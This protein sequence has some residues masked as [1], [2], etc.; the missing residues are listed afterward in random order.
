MTDLLHRLPPP[1]PDIESLLAVLAR[2]VPRR[3]PLFEL[4]IHDRVMEEIRG[5]GMV[6]LPGPGGEGDLRGAVADRVDMWRR[7]GYDYFLVRA[8]SLFSLPHHAAA[9]GDGRGWMD[10]HRGAIR[11]LEECERYPWPGE[12]NLSFHTLEAALECL[13]PGMGLAAFSGGVLEWVTILLGMER[14]MLGLYDEPELVKEVVDRV[15]RSIHHTFA[16]FCREERVA[17]IFLGDDFGYKNATLIH[18]DQLRELILPWLKRYADQAH[19]A[20]KPFVLHSCGCIEAVM[21][22]LVEEV[23]IDARHSFEDGVT[24]VEQVCREWGDRVA[25]LG[26]VDVDILSRGPRERITERTRQVL[27][28]CAPGGGYAAGSGNSIPDYV[29]AENYDHFLE[30]VEEWR[31]R[32]SP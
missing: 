16:R 4:G 8:D 29:P 20:G 11:S 19:A 15:G 23:G 17:F 2:K 14:F 6:P 32:G 28:A 7:L 30:L 3:L 12:E 5:A 21:P 22:D 26:G 9:G 25:V 27:G 13:P 10:E 18:P 1:E 24:P 31:R